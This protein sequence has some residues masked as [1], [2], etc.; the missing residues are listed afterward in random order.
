MPEQT[1]NGIQIRT[2]FMN[3]PTGYHLSWQ[4]DCL[5]IPHNV[6]WKLVSIAD[7]LDNAKEYEQQKEGK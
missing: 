4:K 1:P 5:D 3:L 2:S 6:L 7:D